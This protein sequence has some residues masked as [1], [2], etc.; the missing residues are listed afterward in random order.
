MQDTSKYSPYIRGASDLS[1]CHAKGYLPGQLYDLSSSYGNK[2]E[3]VALV[4]AL[5]AAGIR[6][7]CDIVINHRCAD[8]QDEHGI[9]NKFR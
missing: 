8:A 2:G 4:S 1:W 6:A 7:V 9:W 5:K 3:L